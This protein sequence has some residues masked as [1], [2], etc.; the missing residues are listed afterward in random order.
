VKNWLLAL[1]VIAAVIVF[2][3][4]GIVG[5][6]AE[7][8]LRQ[9]TDWADQEN[10]D[11]AFTTESFDR[12]WFSSEGRHRLSLQGTNQ[13][14]ALGT[15]AGGA[16]PSIVFDTRIDHGIVPFTSLSGSSGSLKPGLART[17]TTVQLD[18]GNGE[19]VPLPGAIRSEISLG[20]ETIGQYLLEA[21]TYE[22]AGVNAEWAGADVSFQLNPAEAFLS[23]DG[24]VQAFS[25][26]SDDG[27]LSIDAIAFSG[28]QTRTPFGFNVGTGHLQ[29]GKI[30]VHDP[31]GNVSG[32]DRF[33]IDANT[34]LTDQRVSGRSTVEFGATAL[35]NFG[36]LAFKLDVV[37]N[38]IDA[39]SLGRIA[40]AMRNARSGYNQGQ[41][42][43]GIFPAIE[44]DLQRLVT[45][46]MEIRIEQLDMSLPQG[47]V[48]SKISIALPESDAS[49]DFSWPGVLLALQ[50]DADLSVSAAL[51]EMAQAM[52]PQAAA[53]VEMGFLVQNGENYEMQAEFAAGLLSING[54]PM[55][56]PMPGM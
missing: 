27:T 30:T 7:R 48:A 38:D 54:I 56:I 5:H 47:E 4:P 6:L 11:I 55:P 45:A 16:A 43:A 46:G 53:V 25:M 40:T 28:V 3:S 9:N 10:P 35:P 52:N 29:M 8:Q 37:A 22:N 2:V 23:A 1:L 32:I 26:R 31:L 41:V 42:M 24:D 19:L 17:V 50:A 18:P 39:A 36:D 14:A 49:A 34:G 13:P 51:V 12:G 15:T 44:A 20:G 21:G 33:N